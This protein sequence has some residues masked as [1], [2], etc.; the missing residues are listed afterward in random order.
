[1]TY[2]GW[3]GGLPLHYHMGPGPATVSMQLTVDSAVS[4]KEFVFIFPYFPAPSVAKD[5]M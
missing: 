5:S 4:A 2:D 3:Q 1:V